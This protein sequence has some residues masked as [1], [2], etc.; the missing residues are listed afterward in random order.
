[1]TSPFCRNDPRTAKRHSEGQRRTATAIAV[2]RRYTVDVR[3]KAAQVRLFNFVSSGS[4][5]SA[6]AGAYA[7]GLGKVAWSQIPDGV[8]PAVVSVEVDVL[9][10]AI[11][12]GAVVVPVR[13]QVRGQARPP[14]LAAD[15]SL[16]SVTKDSTVL[17]LAGTFRLPPLPPGSGPG[18][19]AGLHAAA[20]ASAGSLLA[21]VADALASP[22]VPSQ[23]LSELA[24]GRS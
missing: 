18:D 3:F 4:L 7:A 14:V 23:P 16:V 20:V 11:A 1:M 15:L 2:R 5:T 9:E 12:P 13:W 10:P 24:V 22:V 19:W 17:I 21:N 8:L 6:S